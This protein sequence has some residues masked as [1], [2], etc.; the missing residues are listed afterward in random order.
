MTAVMSPTGISPGKRHLAA[1]SHT[2]RS[3]APEMN[4]SGSRSDALRESILA[5]CGAQSPTQ[6]IIPET[7]T[8]AAVMR[9]AR[10]M[11]QSRDLPGAT[12]E[13][14]MPPSPRSMIRSLK[15]ERSMRAKGTS[16]SAASQGAGRF[17]PSRAIP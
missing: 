15:R 4:E 2:R 11:N 13:S 17:R 6:P 9:E 7:D 8:A 3:P 1:S 10:R 16:T 5:R 14:A 12:P